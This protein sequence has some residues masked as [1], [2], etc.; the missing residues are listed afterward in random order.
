MNL[1][2]VGKNLKND[3]ISFGC[4]I[5]LLR[6]R[7]GHLFNISKGLRGQ[8]Q[9]MTGSRFWVSGF[10]R[11]DRTDGQGFIVCALLC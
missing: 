5:T 2:M 8:R 6:T 10:L 4:L 11:R 9:G 7:L 3:W 1:G